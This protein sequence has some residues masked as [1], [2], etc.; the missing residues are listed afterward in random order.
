MEMWRELGLP[1]FEQLPIIDTYCKYMAPARFDDLLEVHTWVEELR[2]KGFKIGHKVF[3]KSDGTLLAEGHTG[4]VTVDKDRKPTPLFE[5][6]K[7]KFEEH[8]E[9]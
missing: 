9:K 4:F 1:Y 3:R 6:F 5:D 7:K 8:L 2:S